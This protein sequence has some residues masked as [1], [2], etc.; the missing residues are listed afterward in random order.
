MLTLARCLLACT[1]T[2]QLRL[3]L[4]GDEI[5]NGLRKFGLYGCLCWFGLCWF[6]YSD[7]HMDRFELL[8]TESVL[9]T[10][11]KNIYTVCTSSEIVIF[12]DL[13]LTLLAFSFKKELFGLSGRGSQSYLSRLLGGR[14]NPESEVLGTKNAPQ[15]YA[16]Q[17]QSWL[18]SRTGSAS[19]WEWGNIG[20]MRSPWR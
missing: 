17:L 12:A 13:K 10:V 11:K 9:N 3:D 19:T 15:P 16:F 2:R 6:E 14:R 20:A 4:F 8:W 5:I 18:S 7:S 1:M